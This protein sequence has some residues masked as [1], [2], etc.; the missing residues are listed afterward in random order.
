[1][2]PGSSGGQSSSNLGPRVCR[3]G[4]VGGRCGHVLTRAAQSAADRF[5][6][7]A[8]KA[9]TELVE[10]KTQLTLRNEALKNATKL[11][12]ELSTQLKSALRARDKT[13]HSQRRNQRLQKVHIPVMG[14]ELTPAVP[15]L[16]REIEDQARAVQIGTAKTK[17]L[18]DTLKSTS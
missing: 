15:A 5:E 12:R 1:M 6:E 17:K 18:A 4:C 2:T 3:T 11:E 8:N 14:L 16:L 13:E 7:Q 10:A 9:R